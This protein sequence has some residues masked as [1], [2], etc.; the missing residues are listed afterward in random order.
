MPIDASSDD[1]DSLRELVAQ[2]STE[3]DA[4]LAECKRVMEQNDRLRHLLQQLRRAQFG[5]KSERLDPEQLQLAIEDLETAVAAEDAEQDK[6][7]PVEEAPKKKR[8]TNRGSLP[9]HLPR[10]HITLAPDSTACPC[11]HGV[12][13]VIGEETAERLDKI[14]AQYQVIVTHRPKYGCRACEGAIVQAPAQERLIKGGIPTENLVA[15][16]VVDKYA[17]HK[18]LYRQAQIMRLQGLPVDRSTLA[19]WVG[20]AA[21]EIKPVYLRMKEIVLASAKIVVD[22]TRAP[23]LDPGRGRTKTGYFWAISRDDRPWGGLDPPA[24]VY[25]YAPG[26]GGEHCTALLA[27]YTGIVHCDGYTVYKQLADPQRDGGPATLAFCWTH[28]RRGFVEIEEG[29]PAP[30]AHEAL[31]RIAALYA[32]ENRI[33]GRSA[34]ERRAICQT[35]TRPLV[36]ALKTWLENRL[37]AVS[38]K[39][40]IAEVIRYGFN[41]WQG[42]VRFLDDG[43][44]EMDTNSVERAMRPIALNRRNSLFAGH[45]QGAVNWACIA[46]LIETAKLQDIDPKP[47][48]ADI[49]SKLVNGWPMAKIDELLPWAWAQHSKARLAA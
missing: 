19:G 47:Y 9:A 22:E 27:G 36:E 35:Q 17:W 45:D 30:I 31:E 7:A 4:A 34:D 26:R 43:R 15:D 37:A 40:T 2:L 49:L 42:L 18:P 13:H 32:I 21:A 12:M 38:D 28:W 5:R 20:A 10:V 16:V 24:V 25:T 3:R 46:S 39:S 29:G 8:K 33:R 23:V 11:C 48:L 14:P 1:L 41:H 6:T 44:I